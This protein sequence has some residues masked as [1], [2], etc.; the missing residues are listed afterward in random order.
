MIPLAIRVILVLCYICV[1]ISL[2]V[3]GL[4]SL[5][6]GLT[7][8]RL[9]SIVRFGLVIYGIFCIIGMVMLPL[10]WMGALIPFGE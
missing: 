1:F 9:E 4:R 3:S 7:D 6:E 10:H 2:I 5:E 8:D